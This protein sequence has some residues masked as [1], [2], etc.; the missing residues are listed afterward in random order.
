MLV[1]IINVHFSFEEQLIG[2]SI[3]PSISTKKIKYFP[4][5]FFRIFEFKILVECIK[6]I[7]VDFKREPLAKNCAY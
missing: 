5:K 7:A 1:I 3:F 4:R 6:G 2:A